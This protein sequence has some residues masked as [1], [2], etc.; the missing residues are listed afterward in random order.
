[1]SKSI[2]RF[3]KEIRSYQDYG[4][5]Y[6]PLYLKETKEL[7]GCCGLQYYKTNN[8]LLIYELGFHLLPHHWGRGYATEAAK[9]MC[10]YAFED[11]CVDAL[12]A[13]HNPNNVNSKKCLEKLGFVFYNEEFYEPTGLLHP[14]Y[15]LYRDDW[16]NSK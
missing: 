2:D 3:M 8:D 5:Q 11:L 9:V 13:G 12:F 10:T 7:I 4:I 15:I 6:Y 1:M 16:K 14:S